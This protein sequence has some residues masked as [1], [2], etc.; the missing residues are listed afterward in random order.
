MRCHVS[1]ELSLFVFT[2]A[3]FALM[4]TGGDKWQR[5]VAVVT[6]NG[7]LRIILLNFL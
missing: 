7:S 1:L 3:M 5:R 4:Q 2:S 6:N